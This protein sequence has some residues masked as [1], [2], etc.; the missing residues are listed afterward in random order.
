MMQF[1]EKLWKMWENRD[2][3]LITTERIR[4]CLVSQTNFL[5]TQ[6]FTEKLLVIEMK[7]AE[8]LLNKPVCLGLSVVDLGK[9][10]MYEFCFDYVKP[11]YAEKA[12][13]S[14][15]DTDTILLYT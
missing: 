5:T 11:K 4:N 13:L 14:Y 9:I 1:L 3:K 8:I 2:I 12:K 10:L 15:M 7:K 6:F